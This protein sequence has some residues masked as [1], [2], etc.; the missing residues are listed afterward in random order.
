MSD[1]VVFL[2]HVN[3]GNTS[4]Y[5]LDLAYES[6][7][8]VQNS[9]IYYHKEVLTPMKAMDLQISDPKQSANELK[10]QTKLLRMFVAHTPAAVAMCDLKM[11]Y[12]AYSQ[13]W[14]ED[15]GIGDA[16]LVG[17]CHYDLFPDLPEHWKAEHKRCFGGEI[18]KKTEEPFP[19]SDGTTDWV[20]REL[21]PWRDTTGEIG[22]LIMFTEVI[23]KRRQTEK[24]LKDS[25]EQYRNLFETSTV[26]L[27]RSRIDDGQILFAN[28]AFAEI[29]GYDSPDKFYESFKTTEH[30]ADLDRRRELLRLLKENGRID[31]FEIMS[32]R[33]DGTHIE[34][35]VSAIIYPEHGYIEGC[36]EKERGTGLGLASAYGII[37]NH[38]GIITALSE[39]EQGATFNIYLPAST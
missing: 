13:R 7:R 35:A 8:L 18:I 29:M 4:I 27:Y 24:A 10:P 34:I 9:G 16:N 21:C 23:T 25:E 30:Y 31:G 28:Q 14:A 36:I 11:R 33:P 20:R 1:V 22:G 15:Y 37:K 32:I 5:Y 19:R 12:L 17:R 39:K 6:L 26:G 38:D 2:Q 3:W